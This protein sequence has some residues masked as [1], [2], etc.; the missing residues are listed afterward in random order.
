MQIKLEVKMQSGAVINLTDVQVKKITTY[1]HEIVFGEPVKEKRVYKRVKGVKRAWTPEEES[2]VRA[3]MNL[4]KGL[5][6]NKATKKLSIEL[7][8]SR[9]AI[10]QKGVELR[11]AQKKTNGGGHYQPL[12][13]FNTGYLG[14]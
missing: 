12:N 7:K 13:V 5:E 1:V 6:K 14:R 4:P 9:G 8:R 2:A 11:A 3:I 10:C